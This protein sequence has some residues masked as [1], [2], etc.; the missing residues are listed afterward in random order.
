MVLVEL[1]ASE[2]SADNSRLDILS[3]AADCFMERGYGATSIDDVARRL[4]ATKG[5]IYHHFPSKA[6]LFAQIFRTGMDLNYEALAPI[7]SMPGKAIER[8]TRL[9]RAHTMQM[10]KA[11][12]FQRVVWEG[13]EMHLRGSTTPEQ[14]NVLSEL[15][16]YRTRYGDIFRNE[17]AQ[18]RADGDM[19]FE[20]LSI[21]NQI[22]LM[23]L[24]SPIFWYSRR[25]GEADRDTENIVEQV[26]GFA[27]RGLNGKTG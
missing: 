17:I 5:R 18:A 10:I 9:A 19:Q 12:P 7:R 21:A 14:R 23:T 24:N 20:N 1:G 2:P 4:R 26:V 6:D 25:P 27:L 22:A 3:A 8:W 11:K 13:V 16:E 15:I